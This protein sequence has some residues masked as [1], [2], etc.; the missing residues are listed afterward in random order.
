MHKP[1][2]ST[3]PSNARPT[4]CTML[5][6][7]PCVQLQGLEGQE[8]EVRVGKSPLLR[9]ASAAFEQEEGLA[10]QYGSDE[11]ADEELEG[12]EGEEEAEDDGSLD[13]PPPGGQGEARRHAPRWPPGAH[14]L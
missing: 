13:E 6:S 7:H 4:P 8:G 2:H 5:W 10:G 14:G 11:D 12:A 9:G 3:R 1:T